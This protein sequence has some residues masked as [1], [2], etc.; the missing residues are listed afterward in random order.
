MIIRPR[1]R[2]FICATTHPEG[3][4]R[5]VQTQIAHARTRPIAHPPRSALILGSSASYGLASR[6]ALAFGGGAATLG[7]FLDRPPTARK[8]GTAGWYNTAAFE[9]EAGRAGLASFSL[10]G[11]AFSDETRERAIRALR[12]KMPPVDCVIYSI[13]APKRLHPVTGRSYRSVLKPIGRSY[14]SKTVDT[15]KGRVR[16]IVIEPASASE[17]D[18]TI[19]VMGGDDWRR[20]IH[21]LD[22][23]GVLARGCRTIA[24]S[25]I[26]PQLTWPIYRDGSIG[27]A[28]EDLKRAADALDRRLSPR[29]GG[30]HIAVMKAVVTQASAAIPV[31][32]LYISILYK[33]MK[34]RESHEG[35]MEQAARL[36]EDRV[37][38]PRAVVSDE[39]GLIRLD[40]LEMRP[41][42][43]AEIEERWGRICTE[44]LTR[45][46]DFEGYKRD[47]LR[48]FGFEVSGIDYAADVDPMV[49]IPSLPD[50]Q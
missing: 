29:G 45:E 20:W 27:K 22:A 41:D 16:E 38:G 24:Y 32:P 28:K 15:D 13:A 47:F 10:L 3:C 26:G 30:A 37:Y 4:A 50:L 39:R 35:P 34:R 9:R 5:N 2:G 48:L 43:Q 31:V 49:G 12:E 46:S 40:D 18:A 8:P 1:V 21:A 23:A 7:V 36:F 33:A 11:D 6:I 25:Y 44:N 14:S 19:Q 17:T 42:T